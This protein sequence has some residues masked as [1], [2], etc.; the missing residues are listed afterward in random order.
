MKL[1]KAQVACLLLIVAF[2]CQGTWALAGT[3]G[4][5]SGVVTD[6]AT[7]APIADATVTAVSPSQSATVHTDIGGH[8]SILSLAP[9]EYTV[10]VTKSGY[11][12]VS[13][14]GISIFSDQ[15][16]TIVLQT[17]ATLQTIA[18]VTSRSAGDLVKPG[19][20]ADIY[21]VN[22]RSTQLAHPVGGGGNLYQ[23]Y[24]A[25]ATVPGVQVP[26]QA[27]VG[28]NFAAP[29]IRGGDYSQV[30]YE[31][32]GV[33]V[34]RAFDNYATNTQ[35]VT[36][37][38]ELQVYTGGVPAGEAGQGLS[39]YIN[40]VIK[41]G[42]YP[43]FASAELVSGWPT[44]YHSLR[45]DVGGAN[46]SRTFSYYVGV[47]GWNQAYRYGDQF[48]GAGFNQGLFGSVLGFGPGSSVVLGP[49]ALLN[50][51]YITTRE[52][53]INLH[54]GIPHK[55]DGGR[56]DV[57]LLFSGGFQYDALDNSLGLAGPAYLAANGITGLTYLDR[58]VY[59][60]AVGAPFDPS[61]LTTYFYPNT[62]PHAYNQLAIPFTASSSISNANAIEK[63]QYQ[64]N[65]GSNAYIRAY[66]YM[67]YSNWLN[68][69]PVGAAD[70]L[71]GSGGFLIANNADYELN[72]HSRGFEISFADQL[73]AQHLLSASAGYTTATLSRFNQSTVEDSRGE[74]PTVQLRDSFGHCYSIVTGALGNCYSG[75]GS[76]TSIGYAG[77]TICRIDNTQPLNPTL[78][79]TGGA[80]CPAVPAA[81]AAAGA[82]FVVVK[83]GYRGYLNTVEPK[84][85]AASLTDQWRPNEKINVNYGVRFERYEYDLAPTNSVPIVGGSRSM[86]FNDYNL[87]HCYDP[88]TNLLYGTGGTG[89]TITGIPTSAA[90]G[91]SCSAGALDV[92]GNPLPAGLIHTNISNS[93]DNKI[94][95]TV[96]EPRI[97]ATYTLNPDTVL[98]FSAGKYSQP[99]NT[100]ATQYNIAQPDLAAFTAGTFLGFGF[101]TPRHAVVPQISVNYDLSLEKRLHGTNVS[102]KVTPF[103]RKTQDQEQSFFLDPR[104]NF[105]TA[106]N[107]GSER[108]YGVEF[109][110][111]SGDFDRNG[112]SGQLSYSYTNAKTK[113]NNFA[114]TNRNVI[115]LVN[116]FITGN[117]TA[118]I[119]GYNQFTAAGGGFACYPLAG[120]ATSPHNGA[121]NPATDFTNPYFGMPAATPLDRNA[122]YSPY[123][124]FPTTFGVG[125]SISHEVPHVITALAQY[126]H[127]KF[128]FA[129]VLQWDSGDKY[130]SPFSWQ[131][132]NPSTCSSS[133]PNTC[134]TFSVPNPFTG[135]FDR[136]GQWQEPSQLTLSAQASYD[137]SPKMTVT[138]IA[139]NI[140]HH[141]YTH[142]YKWEVAGSFG[143]QYA[144]NPYYLG[145]ALDPT[146]AYPQMQA[147][148]A[149]G[150]LPV[151]PGFPFNAFVS[152][153]VKL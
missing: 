115:D 47:S 145:N 58:I 56:D 19:S 90:T 1:A 137:V 52:G 73:S 3:T 16:Q 39:G 116:D 144:Q 69:D 120:S 27:G 111:R 37:Q 53:V 67:N 12:P 49:V 74:A 70:L 32:D 71:E 62:P 100:S 8:F 64:H 82:S 151:T 94:T 135:Q 121:C 149:L 59:N 146:I 130:G 113:Y 63:L 112:L 65:I 104:T 33:P 2:A 68:S 132:L 134:S 97:G 123:S 126:K 80:P 14:S 128:R 51:A 10:S 127:D 50:P 6:S 102:F 87:E 141:C 38:Q 78:F 57:Q 99:F 21:S 36:G 81:A 139:E 77:S 26:Q 41:T 23:T 118:G 40:Q 136:F 44:F 4:S 124:V 76:N 95:S 131:G 92:L 140:Y 72:S 54:F 43:G 85:T 86:F 17:H 153:Q 108:A 18:S 45:A 5:L 138:V 22:A 106:L 66:G 117:P 152:L 35:G 93:Y 55:R 61:R 119:V 28:Q 98:R 88:T 89:S 83:T 7:N 107:V 91:F 143:C 96:L 148:T 142:N 11:A 122:M 9:D 46:P 125:S 31:Y 20:T 60:G 101:N 34:N 79:T 84:F 48:N 24:A 15:A 25:L 13:T 105:V 114:N 42:T 30:G 133:N 110:I 129:P 109:Q 75:G 147:N 29:F 150:Y 103:Y